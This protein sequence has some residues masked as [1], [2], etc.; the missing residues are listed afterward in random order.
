MAKSYDIEGC[1]FGVK[2]LDGNIE[3]ALSNW[4]RRLRD[5]EKLSILKNKRE[6]QKPSRVNRKKRADAIR[7]QEFNE[8]NKDY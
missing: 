8:Q 1:Y 4:K 2:V 3:G 6:F 5:S 7:Q